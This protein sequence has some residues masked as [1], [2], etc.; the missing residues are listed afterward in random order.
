MLGFTGMTRGNLPITVGKD[1]FSKENNFSIAKE[2]FP[3]GP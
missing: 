1:P 2:Y 3:G